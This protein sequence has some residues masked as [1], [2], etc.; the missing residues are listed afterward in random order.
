MT[1]A[2]IAYNAQLPS[3]AELNRLFA[4]VKTLHKFKVIDSAMR[5]GGKVV[6]KRARQLMPVSSPEDRFKRWKDG[7]ID[8]RREG[9]KS[10]KMSVVQR[11]DKLNWGASAIIGPKYPEGQKI[12]LMMEHKQDTRDVIAWDKGYV[13][14]VIKKR[15]KLTQAFEEKKQAAL[16]AAKVEAQKRIKDLMSV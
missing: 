4:D 5:A 14:F 10:L 13:D 11:V 9:E 15:N 2:K 8:T 12:Y 1:K 6:Q 3:D 7:R 16:A